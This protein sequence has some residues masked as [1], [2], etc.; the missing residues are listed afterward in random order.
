MKVINLLN[1]I[2]NGEEVPKKIKYD[3]VEY[4]HIDN[5]CYADENSRLLSYEIY[6]EQHRLN[7]E[8]EIIEDTPKENK[9]IEKLDLDDWWEIT[10][11][12]DCKPEMLAKIFNKNAKAFSYKINEIIDVVNKLNEQP[13]IININTTPPPIMQG[14]YKITCSTSG[15]ESDKQ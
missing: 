8:I 4:T 15:K 2:A 7:D 14:P 10:S 12:E 9:K 11:S 13:P 3:G 6:A 5:Y 1:K